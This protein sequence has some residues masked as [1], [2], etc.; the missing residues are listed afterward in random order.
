MQKLFILPILAAAA[1]LGLNG[2]GKIPTWGELTGQTKPAEPEAPKP[3]PVVQAPVAPV[4]PQGPTPEQVIASFRAIP[5]SQMSDSALQQLTSLNEGL[6]QVTEINADYSKVTAAGLQSIDKLKNL[7]ILRLDSTPVND[8]ACQSI[9]KATSIRT[10]NLSHTKI[11]S[12]GIAALTSLVN[13][14]HLHLDYCYLSREAF[15]AIGTLPSL[16]SIS[17]VATNVDNTGLDRICNAKTLEYLKM[18]DNGALDDNGL[19]FLKKLDHLTG[20]E[21]ASTG[22][23][24]VGLL[25]AQKG[26]GLKSMKT[27]IIG[28]CPI[29]TEGGIAISGFKNLEY[30][31]LIEISTMNDLGLKKVLSGMKHLRFLS[32]SKSGTLDGSGL[33]PLAN[34]K[35]LEEIHLDGCS[36]IGDGVVKILKTIKSLKVIGLG[37]T[38]VTANGMSVLRTELPDAK[39]Q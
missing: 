11:T 24:G 23:N 39:I 28:R 33:M 1:V 6:D 14:N 22:I 12:V 31:S 13:L 30:L 7:T 10:L 9:G 35:E 29:G 26:G 18:N 38:S 37:G 4:Q 2:C 20:L 36:R 17:L 5:P 25:S 34:H 16:I 8:E 21:L 3:A 27:L 19:V 15:D 32:L